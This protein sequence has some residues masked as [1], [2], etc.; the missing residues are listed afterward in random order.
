MLTETVSNS[1]YTV[2]IQGVTEVQILQYFRTFNSGEFQ[3]TAALFAE[4]GLL[5]APFEDS[6]YGREAIAIYLET[7]AQGMQLRP[8]K[9]V[10]ETLENAQ[11][12]VQVMGKVK[13]P[14]FWVNVAWQFILNSD[15]EIAVV[16]VKLLASLQEL[17]NL[18][19]KH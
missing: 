7:E 1:D 9:G 10:S 13:T 17:L 8:Q 11:Q 3:T 15:G 12:Q 6:I 5:E 16:T 19:N 4:D 14:L 2:K 18:Q